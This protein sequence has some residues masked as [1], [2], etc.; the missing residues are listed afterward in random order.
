VVALAAAFTAGMFLIVRPLLG[1]VSVAYD[2]VGNV[3]NLWIGIIFAGV[4]L[5][6][7]VAQQIG[8]AAIFGAFMMGLI[9][10]RHAG[11]TDDVN[12]R[13]EDFVVTVL[14]PLF[15]V[16]TGLR[17]NVGS[18][19]R[20]DLWVVALLLLAVAIAGKFLG[21]MLAARYSGMSLRDSAAVGTLMNTRGLTEL[22]VL[23]IGLD[24]GLISQALFTMLVIMALITT[25]MAGPALD[26]LDPKGELSEPPEEELRRAGPTE[27]AVKSILVA[28]QDDKNLDALLTFAE[29]LAQSEPPRELILA[30]LV[31]PARFAAGLSYVDRELKRE[32][33]ELNRRRDALVERG[34]AVRVVAFTSPDVGADLVRLASEQEVDLL[35]MDGRR[36]L[37]GERVPRGPVM[38][39]LEKAPCDVAVLVEREGALPRIDANHPVTVPFGGAEH[40]WAALEVGAWLAHARQAPLK[41]LGASQNGDVGRDASR[42]LA[43]ASLVVQQLAG[44]AAEPVLVQP[45][46]ALVE[47]A[48]GSGVL[49]VGLSDRWREEGL[50]LVRSEIAKEAP[51]PTIFVRRGR[52]A[53]VLAARDDLT[54]FRW[55]TAG[56]VPAGQPPPA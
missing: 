43:N 40:D 56:P 17:T 15:F 22:I 47:A 28:C 27:P 45:G 26:L 38:P 50:G 44:V 12:R 39:V 13:L 53:G 24:L 35:L 52:R 51:A 34:I 2:E 37:V 33:A 10:P 11:L 36:P 16:V 25:F 55:S 54:R 23:N 41:L 48:R 30:R 5:S 14:L 6:A 31:A 20:V 8:I 19:N 7:Y 9:M 49:V 18:L 4:L 3:P 1:R 42:L 32:S 29:P 46:P 21:A